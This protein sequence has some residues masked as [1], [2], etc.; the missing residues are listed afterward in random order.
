MNYDAR[1]V[2]P[3]EC[4]NFTDTRTL[5]EKQATAS[6]RTALSNFYRES[7]MELISLLKDIGSSV[8]PWL[9]DSVSK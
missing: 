8:P 6:E 4:F 7:N 9:R 3:T 5:L 2:I 1:I